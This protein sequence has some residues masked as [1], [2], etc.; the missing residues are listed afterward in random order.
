MNVLDPAQRAAL[1]AAGAEVI[2]LSDDRYPP[3]LREIHDPPGQLYVRG[4]PGL[5]GKPQL[6]KEGALRGSW[7]LPLPARWPF[8]FVEDGALQADLQGQL[9]ISGLLAA[10]APGP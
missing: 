7:E 8:D 1:K 4:D 10:L 5:L 2:S 3:L 9:H 6:A